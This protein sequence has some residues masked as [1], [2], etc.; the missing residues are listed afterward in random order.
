[1]EHLLSE[2]TTCR[3]GYQG[4]V[5]CNP[6]SRQQQETER[7]ITC[8][9]GKELELVWEAEWYQLIIVGPTIIPGL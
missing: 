1:M 8:L 7:A 9:V 2:P 3:D 4:R 6:G 5:Y